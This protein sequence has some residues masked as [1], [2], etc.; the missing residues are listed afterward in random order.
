MI[1]SNTKEL[2][3]F[4][5]WTTHPESLTMN[6]MSLKSIFITSVCT[7]DWVP[8]PPSPHYSGLHAFCLGCSP[9]RLTWMT[10]RGQRIWVNEQTWMMPTV[11]CTTLALNPIKISSYILGLEESFLPS[12]YR[13]ELPSMFNVIFGH[14]RKKGYLSNDDKL[15]YQ[16]HLVVAANEPSGLDDTAVSDK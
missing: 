10:G 4:S 16:C 2:Q 9:V 8:I 12:F 5:S 6:D 14:L 3:T 13:R 7:W 1:R 11:K 15:E